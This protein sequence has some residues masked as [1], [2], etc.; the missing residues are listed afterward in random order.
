MIR[1]RQFSLRSL[2]VATALIAVACAAGR[3]YVVTN[4]STKAADY[5]VLAVIS[6][7]IAISGAI[8]VLRGRLLNWVIIGALIDLGVLI[9]VPILDSLR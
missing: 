5:R 3:Y 2:L 4:Y 7:P 1:S 8:G 9:V 6:I